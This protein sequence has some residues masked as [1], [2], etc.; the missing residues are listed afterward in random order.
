[1]AQKTKVCNYDYIILL[2]ENKGLKLV[3]LLAHGVITQMY[4]KDTFQSIHC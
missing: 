2:I 3:H 4:R 1:M